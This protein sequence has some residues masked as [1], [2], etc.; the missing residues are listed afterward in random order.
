MDD[1]P[2][3]KLNT[4]RLDMNE[5]LFDKVSS[6]YPEIE[7][8]VLKNKLTGDEHDVT[9]SW[10]QQRFDPETLL[11]VFNNSNPHWISYK[12]A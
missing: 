3:W 4:K 8:Y 11:K 2:Q 7:F 5:L 12:K 10:L 6:V 9:M 1:S